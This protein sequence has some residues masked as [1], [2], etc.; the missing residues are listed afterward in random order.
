MNSLSYL[1]SK[2]TDNYGN[3]HWKV[4]N[5]GVSNNIPQMRSD[6]FQ[7]YFC[8]GGSNAVPYYLGLNGHTSQ[9]SVVSRPP[10]HSAYKKV[11]YEKLHGS[12]FI[13]EVADIG[14]NKPLMDNLIKEGTNIGNMFKAIAGF[15][16]FEIGMRIGEPI[17]HAIGHYHYGRKGRKTRGRGLQSE[18]ERGYYTDAYGM[19]K[20]DPVLTPEITEVINKYKPRFRKPNPL[21]VSGGVSSDWINSERNLHARG[22]EE[23]TQKIRTSQKYRNL[24]PEERLKVEE[25][26]RKP[27]RSLDEMRYLASF[28]SNPRF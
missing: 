1:P 13:D 24:P 28:Y 20:L 4:G 7:P 12:G 16:P 26:I 2:E 5:P 11:V 21:H 17:G 10:V 27:T 8:T 15:N 14:S 19:P 6:G 25:I 23:E 22:K 3:W 9:Q 18:K